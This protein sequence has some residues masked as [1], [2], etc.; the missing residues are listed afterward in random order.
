MLYLA[1]PNPRSAPIAKQIG[2]PPRAMKGILLAI[3][4]LLLFFVGHA[5]NAR[6]VLNSTGTGAGQHPWIV[7]NPD[8]S[9]PG[10]YLVID[11]P[12]LNAITQVG[13]TAPIIKSEAEQ[14]KIRWATG[15]GT[16]VY[17]IPFAT[18]S[19]VAIPLSI[20]K[21]TPGIGSGSLIFS[22]YNSLGKVP[23][24]PVASG[25][26][27][28]LYRPS[29]VTHM[30]DYLT[31]LVNNS[32]YVIDRFWIIDAGQVGFNYT[33]KP[34]VNITFGFDPSERDPNGGNSSILLGD[35][36]AQRF[37]PLTSQWHDIAPMGTLS[38]NTVTA[39]TLP[40][41]GDFY[42]SWTLSS[43]THPLPITLVD[44]SGACDGRVVQL[45]WTTAS[46]QDNAYFTIEKSHDAND[47][48]ELGQLAGAGNSSSMITYGFIDDEN[49]GTAYY[50][51]RQTDHNGTTTVSDVIAVG[52][53]VEGGTAIVNTW[54]SG[55]RLNVVVSSTVAGMYDLTLMDAQGKVVA[56]RSA[57]VVNVGSTTLSLDQR[58]IATGIYV[59]QLKNSVNVMSRR[60]PVQ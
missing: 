7:F 49:T 54:D 47:W 21:S 17:V 53:G 44:W 8:P 25:W 55:D 37:N 12:N 46:E 6:L 23:G 41:V 2:N 1:L 20:N 13:P 45:S 15:I 30:Y 58:N 26:D 10:V 60:L 57:Q 56:S 22:T 39:V 24:V 27:N 9:N 33:T 35:L 42:R 32:A 48:Y 51:L 29:D 11:N 59:I 14:N 36:V 34:T 18:T 43:S 52:C 31:G 40:T 5:Q 4:G 16:G 38:G 19:G 28:N 3:A 50:R